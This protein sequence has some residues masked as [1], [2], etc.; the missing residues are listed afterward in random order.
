MKPAVDIFLTGA[1]YRKYFGRVM[2]PIQKKYS[3]SRMDVEILFYLMNA[4]ESDDRLSDIVAF[5]SFNKG[6][7]S[8]AVTGMEQRGLLRRIPDARDSRRLHIRLEPATK[9]LTEEIA[10]AYAQVT[11]VIYD[12]C[13][14]ADIA[15]FRRITARITDNID[16]EID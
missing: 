11:N 5:Q 7:A 9:P 4:D 6:Q 2:A 14:E 13:S 16:R 10:R 12:G 3:L 8:R 1:R 15:E